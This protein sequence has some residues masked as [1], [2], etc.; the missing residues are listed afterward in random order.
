MAADLLTAI[1]TA[2]G[3]VAVAVAVAGASYWFTKKRER[4][5]ELRKEK[6][7][8]LRISLLA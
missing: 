8:H 6:L 1:V 3:A 5:A 7:E 2:S 4:D